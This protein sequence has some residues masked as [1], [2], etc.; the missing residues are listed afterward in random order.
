MKFLTLIFISL[1]TAYGYVC[2][3]QD[4]PT[5]PNDYNVNNQKDGKWVYYYDEKG[6]SVNKTDSITYYRLI[7][8]DN[9]KP[10][11]EMKEYYA[12]GSPKVIGS[13]IS[14]DPEIYHGKVTHYGRS[15][16]ISRIRFYENG[17]ENLEKSANLYQEAL[18]Q[19]PEEQ[20]YNYDFAK[21]LNRMGGVLKK[22]SQYAK[23]ESV[24]KKSINIR[25][26][27]L[28][29]QHS[30]YA[31]S[32]NSLA[33]LYKEIGRYTDAE[34]LYLQSSAVYKESLGDKHSSYATSLNNLALL[35]YVMGRYSE[36]EALFVESL[37]I[38]EQTSGNQHK[39]YALV[40][41]NLA[42]IYREMGRYTEAEELYLQSQELY[43]ETWG[44]E[45]AN[46][47]AFLK[48]M[49]SLYQKMG[50]YDK[51]ETL[52]L[53]SLKVRKVALGE[54]HPY[55]AVSLNSLASLYTEMGR[56]TDAEP[57]YKQSHQIYKETWGV[58][59]PY[60]AL[61]LY[62][63][64]IIDQAINPQN[65][66]TESYL[67]KSI[68][69]NQKVYGQ[70][71]REVI[72]GK[73]QLLRHQYL[74]EHEIDLSVFR[75]IL[76]FY[77]KYLNTYFDY[78]GETEREAFYKTVKEDYEEFIQLAFREAEKHPELLAEVCNLQLQQKAILLN[79]SNQIKK[80]ILASGDRKLIDLYDEVEQLRQR[81]GQIQSLSMDAQI[82]FGSEKDSLTTILRQ[83][84]QQLTR[85]STF[86]RQS[87]NLPKW[88]SIRDQLDKNTALVE[89]VRFRL[90]DYRYSRFSEKVQYGAFIIT[91]N[92]KDYPDFVLYSDGNFLEEKAVKAYQNLIQHKIEDDTS[93]L[94]FWSPLK[95]KLKRIDKVYFSADGVFNQL[96]MQ[97]LYDPTNDIYL[98]EEVDLQ[99]VSSGKDL[100][101]K[102]R[103]PL[104]NQYAILMGNPSF[105]RPIEEEIFSD[106]REYVASLER[107]NSLSP[108]PGTEKEVIH[109]SRLLIENKWRHDT[110][111]GPE[112]KEAILKDMLKPKVLH[113]AT[114]GFFQ[115]DV[116]DQITYSSN[117]L[118]RSGLFLSG[119]RNT[120]HGHE[121]VRGNTQIGKEDGILTAFEAMNLN[122]DNTDLVVLS[123]CETGLGE[124]RNGE[125]VYGLQRAFKE[126]GARSIL[127]SLW[128]V[129]DQTTQELM[130]SFYK[131]WLG[132]NT[133]REA[134]K[135]AQLT[136]KESKPH[137]YYWGAFVL[138][139][140]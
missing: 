78:L 89:L 65:D 67:K 63:L 17:V 91:A 127:M 105:G 49:A 99:L 77:H 72:K 13:L 82:K 137:A 24:F 28:G 123:A 130:L 125:G 9:G 131:N 92:T 80:R 111:L 100:L 39:Y 47:G 132:G 44:E 86:Y 71:S 85:Y 34:S 54:Q 69:I 87:Q 30:G 121:D 88:E 106:Q 134:F 52:Y 41:S 25:K 45:H 84:D 53:E 90:Y 124:I 8:Y 3:G 42:G 23:A 11:G 4:L 116:G 10:I 33:S 40:K 128:K 59:H 18:N 6:S 2:D 96:N 12:N 62:N 5:L 115:E 37:E 48:N 122:I 139:G 120:L 95:D 51:A 93:Y 27:V 119:A 58:D 79:T 101:A 81:L 118:Y 107:G 114:H 26:E 108:L 43:K 60:F 94:H 68:A 97:T 112:A 126:A 61:S 14:E 109:I 138:I 19:W 66:S 76:N 38:T 22:T 1:F 7:S 36:S 75:E 133:K 57:L 103:P 117:P 98:F 113:V 50:R 74:L 140:E 104:P 110:Y 55:Y 21:F 32:L 29:E 135:K 31:T 73:M 136:I 64:A 46:Y 16:A 20:K 15:G 102:K 129:D 70:Q 35:Y 56:F 83:K